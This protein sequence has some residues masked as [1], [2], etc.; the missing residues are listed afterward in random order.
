MV[1]SKCQQ[2]VCIVKCNHSFL[3]LE[4][5]DDIVIESLFPEHKLCEAVNYCEDFRLAYGNHFY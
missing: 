2:N 4:Q 1:L 3:L 5:L